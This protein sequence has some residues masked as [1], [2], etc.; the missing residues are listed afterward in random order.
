[1]FIDDILAGMV[2]VISLLLLV[3]ALIAYRRY[4][5]KAML[6]NSFIFILFLINAIIYS[7][8]SL[9]SLHLD[10]VFYFLL[11]DTIILFSL[12]F[13]IALKG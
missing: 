1:M 13:A 6:V 7:L 9:F 3:V 11:F 8:N 5:I 4:K 12:Y 2:I 10:M